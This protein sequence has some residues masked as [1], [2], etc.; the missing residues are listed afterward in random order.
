MNK[1]FLS[2]IISLAALSASAQTSYDAADL[3]QSDLN[4]TARYVGMG[5]ALNALGADIS[6]MASNPAGTGL[7]RSSDVSFTF[8][9]VITGNEGQLG[10]DRGRM[11]VDQGGVLFSFQTDDDGR[12]LQFVNFGVNYKKNRN[13]WGNAFVPVGNLDNTFSQTIQIADLSTYAYYNDQWGFLADVS[14]PNPNRENPYGIVG[15]GEESYLGVP[16][17]K[18]NYKRTTYG[19]N[20]ECDLNLSFNSSDRFYY[21]LSIG[22]Y[23]F[24]YS[25]ESFYEELGIDG[26]YY[27]FSNWYRTKGTGVD[28][29]LGFICRPIEDSPFRF[30]IAVHTPTWYRL[31]YANGSTLYLNDE[32][33]DGGDSGDRDFNFTSPWKFNFSLG[34]TIGNYLALGAEYEYTD[35]S[36]SKY[37]LQACSDEYWFDD[38]N[39][40]IKNNLKGQHTFKLGIE[41]KP[42]DCFSIRAGYNYV[43]SAFKKD[44]Y[45]SIAYAEPYTDTDYTNWGA[46]NRVTFGL[47]YRWHGG[48]FDV[49]Y[50][51][52]AQK[53]D[54]YAFDN[55]WEADGAVYTLKPTKIS[56]NRSQI[57]ATIGFKF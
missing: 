32:F 35:F 6:T 3:M 2:S 42:V 11:S 56:N 19:S 39:A 17:E 8:G 29:K 52:Q 24:D 41:G 12:G 57:L 30:G 44:A 47:G 5:G 33:V 43:S 49:A 16:A 34:H 10:H 27:D 38:F 26:E 50:Q 37:K 20:V 18:A 13:F 15:V 40:A 45:N 48:Y 25:R 7:Y 28:F 21:G 36:A 31:T 14:A 22:I 53:G 4:G 55:Y 9:G 46:I 23:D 51:Y 54:F 1:I